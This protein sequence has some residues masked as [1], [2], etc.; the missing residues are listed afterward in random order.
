MRGN[1]PVAASIAVPSVLLGAG[2]RSVIAF[3]A[4]RKYLHAVRMDEP[5]AVVA[6]PLSSALRAAQ[7]KG[8]PYPVRRAAR[9]YLESEIAKTGRARR[10]LRALARGKAAA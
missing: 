1:K 4:G 8:K 10:V 9:L 2:G 5:I 7:L 6:I 3:Q